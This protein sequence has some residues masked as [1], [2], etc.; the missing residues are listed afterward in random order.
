MQQLAGFL[1]RISRGRPFVTLKMACSIDGRIAISTDH[2]KS[3]ETRAIVRGSF[4]YSATQIAPD[5]KNLL[6]FYE[7][8]SQLRL[9]TIPFAKLE[10]P[11]R[12]T[13][14]FAARQLS[15]LDGC[16]RELA[17]VTDSLRSL[18]PVQ[19][20]LLAVDLRIAHE[21]LEELT[22][23]LTTEATLDRIFARFCLGK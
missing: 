8:Q 7:T 2:G 15:Q 19:P 18:T 22:G 17:A 12:S 3:F 21:H 4:G 20:E 5:R 6:C 23:A 1:S 14:V 11:H 10:D 13:A 9:L 16:R